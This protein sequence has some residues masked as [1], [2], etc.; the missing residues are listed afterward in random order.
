MWGESPELGRDAIEPQGKVVQLVALTRS[1]SLRRM[2]ERVV[3]QER[4]NAT[5]MSRPVA[6][7]D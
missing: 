6:G 5:L 3:A 4:R 2:L 7:N 1:T